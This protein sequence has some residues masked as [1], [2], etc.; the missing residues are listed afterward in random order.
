MSALAMNP[1]VVC[2]E[3]ED[4]A[5]LARGHPGGDDGGD[6]ALDDFE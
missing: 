5:V 6:D 4:G 1:E 3:L 2:T